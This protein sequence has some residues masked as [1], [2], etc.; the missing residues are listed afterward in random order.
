MIEEYIPIDG[1]LSDRDDAQSKPFDSA[2]KDEIIK[3]IQML[4]RAFRLSGLSRREAIG[5]LGTT[6]AFGDRDELIEA[7][8]ADVPENLN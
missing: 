7:A 5:R 8:V 4:Y 2:R 6:E 1:I 3:M